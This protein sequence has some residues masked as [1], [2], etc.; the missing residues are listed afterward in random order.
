MSRDETLDSLKGFLILL[1]ILGHLI[2][3]LKVP[4]E[5]VWNLIY[6]FHMPLFVLVSGYL[7][8]RDYSDVSAIIKPL[9][10]FQ[11]INI[12]LLS[13]LGSKF[14]ITYFLIPHWTLWYLLSLAFWRLILRYT[15]EK[16]IGHPHTY[17]GITLLA[18]IIIGLFLPYGRVLSIQRTINFLP[19]FIMGYYFRTGQIKQKICNNTL[20]VILFILVSAICLLGIYPDNASILLRGADPYSISDLPAKIFILICTMVCIYA[21]WNLKRE[22]AWLAEIGK[23]SLMYYLYHGLIIEF[24]L[25]PIVNYYNLPTGIL[26]ISAYFLLIIIITKLMNRFSVFIWIINPRQIEKK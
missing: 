7:S 16:L 19:F 15:P 12:I 21:I 11:C 18:T 9:L 20:T 24:I 1:V 8:K 25:V 10:V 14:S 26:C 2:G 3:S 4:C 5:G 17:L 13:I 6:T 23:N 22:V